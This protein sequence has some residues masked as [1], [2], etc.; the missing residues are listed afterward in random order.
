MEIEEIVKIGEKIKE[1]YMNEIE[2]Y[3]VYKNIQEVNLFLADRLIKDR[4][5]ITSIL[6]EAGDDREKDFFEEDEDD[7]S[8]EEIED[9]SSVDYF[10][11]LDRSRLPPSTI[12][13]LEEINLDLQ[14]ELLDDEIR[15]QVID[16]VGELYKS[17][18]PVQK[19]RI[20]SKVIDNI[21]ENIETSDEEGEMFQII[22]EVNIIDLIINVINFSNYL[23]ENSYPNDWIKI[24][25][26]EFAKP[27]AI[28]NVEIEPEYL[29]DVYHIYYKKCRTP[30][31]KL[32][33]KISYYKTV[34]FEKIY[35]K[36]IDISKEEAE[37]MLKLALFQ[38]C[39]EENWSVIESAN[40]PFYGEF[41]DCIVNEQELSNHSLLNDIALIN[42]LFEGG[43][44]KESIS[45]ISFDNPEEN[46]IL[47][48]LKKIK[49]TKELEELAGNGLLKEFVDEKKDQVLQRRKRENNNIPTDVF[50]AIIINSCASEESVRKMMN[51]ID[52]RK[53]ETNSSELFDLVSIGIY[54]EN[55]LYDQID[56]MELAD[57][58]EM[59]YQVIKNNKGKENVQI[60]KELKKKLVK[61]FKVLDAVLPIV[62]MNFESEE[63]EI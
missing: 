52:L 1:Q 25:I 23:N 57:I 14:D 19:G 12:R 3:I 38:G 32:G 47:E 35:G 9:S 17:K 42:F 30:I 33:V 43:L 7:Q 61:F 22:N 48:M 8:Y 15:E 13:A 56:K 50:C 53:R 26:S 29:K 4:E 39:L 46:R 41:A 5:K 34:L 37:E 31:S 63:I 16:A 62:R 18:N 27:L 51:G 44:I 11:N 10:E 28:D 6:R 59:L 21:L 55:K 40:G 58:G 2:K 54:A 36:K 24:N 49:S 20:L 45:R 60:P